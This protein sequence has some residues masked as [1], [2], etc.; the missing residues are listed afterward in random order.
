MAALKDYGSRGEQKMTV[1]LVHV[2]K[3]GQAIV[4]N[5]NAHSQGGGVPEN[6]REQRHALG[7]APGKAMPCEI[8]A[9]R[10]AMP[11]TCRSRS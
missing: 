10:D 7:H 8:E 9:E 6:T 3:G 4:G 11:G 5:V 1:Q 2:S